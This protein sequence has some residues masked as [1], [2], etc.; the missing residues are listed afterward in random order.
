MLKPLPNP[1]LCQEQSEKYWVTEGNS[2]H[3]C[4]AEAAKRRAHW[5]TESSKPGTK[6]V[7]TPE[8]CFKNQEGGYPQLGPYQPSATQVLIVAPLGVALLL[9]QLRFL[10]PTH[11][12]CQRKDKK[13]KSKK[14]LPTSHQESIHQQ[15]LSLINPGSLQ[16]NRSKHPKTTRTEGRPMP[17]AIWVLWR[18]SRTSA[19]L[20]FSS[21]R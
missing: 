8:P 2:R 12:T 3:M 4:K 14:P 10:S 20:R 21:T 15:L 19:E 18:S 7:V 9:S 5:F 1:D 6:M 16:P 17:H 13:L 11:C